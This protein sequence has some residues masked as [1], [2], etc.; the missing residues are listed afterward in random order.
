MDP[1]LSPPQPAPQP[2]TP[3]PAPM[4]NP[5]NIYPEV[6]QSFDPSKP[7]PEPKPFED[8][9]SSADNSLPIG[10]VIIAVIGIAGAAYNFTI[11]SASVSSTYINLLRLASGLDLIFAIGLLLRSNLA[12]LGYILASTLVILLQVAIVYEMLHLKSELNTLDAQSRSA[13]SEVVLANPTPEKQQEAATLI[14]QVTESEQK[15]NTLYAKIYVERG[16]VV[17]FDV[18]VIYYLTR[19]SV[20][21]HFT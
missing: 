13:I 2:S 4:H 14:S 21:Q 1:Q 10:V 6:M 7:A 12:R 16:I 3:P 8:E 5:G 20:R 15:L 19:K 9:P 17:L 18:A 11:L